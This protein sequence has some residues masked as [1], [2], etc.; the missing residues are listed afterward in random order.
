MRQLKVALIVKHKPGPRER[1][2]RNMGWWSYS[3]PEFTWEHFSLGKPFNLPRSQFKDYDVIFHEDGSGNYGV[4]RGNGPPIVFLSVDSTLT[5][6]HYMTRLNQARCA[7]LILVDHDQLDRFASAGPP[8]R[9]WNY[10]VNDHAYKP[11]A[12]SIDVVYHCS[13]STGTGA[14]GAEERSLL[15]AQLDGWCKAGGW[16]YV[17]GA[18][19]LDEYTGNMGAG[20]IV[21]NLPRTPINRPHRMFDAMACGACVL[22]GD[23]PIIDGDNILPGKHYHAFSN[24]AQIPAMLADLLTDNKWTQAAI[25]GHELVMAQ[26]TWSVR[27]AQLRQMLAEELGL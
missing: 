17:S 10:C 22:T 27:A 2:R 12:K 5:D 8:V 9:R 6:G 16:S 20:R 7:D 19:G 1:E 24:T 14:P 15:R 3:I 13:S 21:V 23:I 18:V 4:W 26:H 25:D 11:L